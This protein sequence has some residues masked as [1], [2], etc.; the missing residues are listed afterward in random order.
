MAIENWIGNTLGLKPVFYFSLKSIKNN[1]S[2]SGVRVWH[3]H[4]FFYDC[5]EKQR[6]NTDDGKKI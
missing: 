3:D 5:R 6:K 4:Y 2:D 1:I